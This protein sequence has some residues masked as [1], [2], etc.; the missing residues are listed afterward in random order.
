[1]RRN[2]KLTDDSW[3]DSADWWEEWGDKYYFPYLIQY[4]NIELHCEEG[5]HY[6]SHTNLAFQPSLSLIGVHFQFT[7]L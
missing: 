3:P 5:K 7:S 6:L 2:Q 1:M 4:Y